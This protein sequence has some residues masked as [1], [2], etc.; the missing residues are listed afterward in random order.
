[1]KQS[2]SSQYRALWRWTVAGALALGLVACGGSNDDEGYGTDA[3]TTSTLGAALSG[4]Q[5]TTP[6]ITGA[7]GTGTLSLTLPARALSGNISINGMTAAAAHVHLGEVGSNGAVIVNLAE[8]TPGS[9]SWAVPAGTVLT[10]AQATAFSAGGLYFN[11]HTAENPGGEIRGQIGREVYAAQL[12]ASQEVPANVSTAKGVGFVSLDPTTKRVTAR[13]TVLGIAATM[14]HIHTGAVGANGGVSFPMT[15]TAT[16]SGIWVSAADATMTDAQ[17][18]A[19]K[20][21]GLYFNVHS[22][23]YPGGEIRGQIAR[24]VGTASLNAAQEV[25]TNASTATGVGTLVIDPATRAVSGGITLTGIT[26]TDAHIHT[27]APGVNGPVAVGLTNAGGGV[28]NVPANSTMTAEQ[29]KA[30]KQGNLYFNAHSAAFPGGE[31]R[32]QI[33]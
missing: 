11:A 6:T 1:M 31:I 18:T 23:A 3:P 5:E 33:R 13:V 19:M 4:D 32:G 15:E 16:G 28:W 10:E 8:S 22:A 20:A 17:I 27:G 2:G 14:A 26:A 30:F 12:S 25:P 29:L 7:L 24:N 21:G 9:G